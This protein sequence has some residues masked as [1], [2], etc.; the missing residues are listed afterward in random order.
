MAAVIIGFGLQL[1]MG[2]YDVVWPL[3]MIDLGADVAFIGLTFMLLGLPSMILAP[4]FGGRLK[5]FDE[6]AARAVKGIVI[7]GFCAT[8]IFLFGLVGFHPIFTLDMII[9]LLAGLARISRNYTLR[10]L[11]A[12]AAHAA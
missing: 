6:P 7:V 9:G 3:F 4:V 2:I 8:P 11:A 12:R 1:T 5:G 10:S